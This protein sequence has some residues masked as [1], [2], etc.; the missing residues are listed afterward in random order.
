MNKR[1]SAIF[2][3][4]VFLLSLV[5]TSCSHNGKSSKS[6]NVTFSIDRQTVNEILKNGKPDL[7]ANKSFRT[8]DD[9]AEQTDSAQDETQTQAQD[10][11]EE[12][13]EEEEPEDNSEVENAPYDSIF[14]DVSI[15]GDDQQTKTA[16]VKENEGVS[17]VFRRVPI[18]A[19]VWASA[20][21]YTYTDESKTSKMIVY[22][23]KS[24]SII[25][26]STGNKLS[27]LLEKAKLTVTFDSNGGTEVAP[28]EVVT[29]E[30]L[31]KPENPTLSNKKDVY[32]FMG[33]YTDPEFT[34]LYDFDLPVTQDLTL[35]A[36]WLSDYVLVP[37]GEMLNYLKTG[38]DIL[39]VPEL[40][41]CQHEVTQAEYY[42]V[43][44]KDPSLRDRGT[45]KVDASKYPVENVSWYDAIVYCNLLSIKEGL[46]PCYTIKDSVKPAD[47]GDVPT[48]SDDDWNLVSV[49]L[50]AGGYRL[51]TEAEWEYVATTGMDSTTKAYDDLVLYYS[52]SKNRTQTVTNRLVDGLGIC[53]ILGNVSEWCFDWYSTSIDS[54]A[55]LSGPDYGSS[56]VK[57]GGDYSGT[58]KECSVD[59]RAYAAPYYKD[60]TIGF[61]VARVVHEG[62]AP[63]EASVLY[64][65]TYEIE[66]CDEG[67]LTPTEFYRKEEVKLP[68]SLDREGYIFGGWYKT[69]TYEDDSKITGWGRYE[70]NGDITVYGKWIPITYTIKFN[71]GKSTSTVEMPDQVFTYDEAQELAECAFDAPAGLKF[72]GWINLDTTGHD[73]E[74][75]D[76]DYSDKQEVVNLTS[77][78]GAVITLYALWVNKARGNIKYIIDGS[79]VTG[80]SP[81]SYLPSETVDLPT[82]TTDTTNLART[83]YTFS[84]WFT[85]PGYNSATAITG[86]ASGTKEDDIP[87]YGKF[88]PISY[89]ITYVGEGDVWNWESGYTKPAAYTI[90]DNVTLP[91]ASNVKRD[92]YD[93]GGWYFDS[94]L[95]QAASG[96]WDA[97]RIE[98]VTLYAKWSLH[99]Y[100]IEFNLNDV[101]LAGGTPSKASADNTVNNTVS[102]FT[103]ESGPITLADPSR[104]GYTFNG[105]YTDPDFTGEPITIV[106]PGTGSTQAHSDVPLYAKW[107]INTNH[108][109]YKEADDTSITSL[110][111]PG[112][113]VEDALIALGTPEKSGYDFEGWYK[114]ATCTGTAITSIT[115]GGGSGQ[116]SSDVN[117]Y[118]KWSL[119]EY[120]VN[121]NVNGGDS[122]TAGKFSVEQS[123]TLP[124]PTKAGCYFNGWCTDEDL[125]SSAVAAGTI[126]DYSSS[127]G[128][129]ILDGSN[130]KTLELYAKWSSA[131]VGVTVTDPAEKISLTSS[132]PDSSGVI[133]F[134]ATTDLSA[135][136]T[137]YVDGVEDTSATGNTFTFDRADHTKGVYTITVECGGYSATTSLVA[138]IGTKL[139]PDAVLDIVFTD[140]SAIAYQSGL[141]LSDE[142]KAA[143]VAVI[144]YTGTECSNDSRQRILGLGLKN[145]DSDSTPTYAWAKN[146]STGYSTKFTNIAISKSTQKPTDGTVY[147]Q[148]I[149]N[150]FTGD[151][152]GSDNWSYICLQDLTGTA[153]AEVV[154]EN[155]P[156]FNYVNNYAVKAGLTGIYATGWYMPSL[157]ESHHIY[158]KMTQLNTILGLLN[159]ADIL[160][161][162]YYWSS[163]QIANSN[164]SVWSV[165]F[166]SGDV[167]QD[168]KSNNLRVCVI[169][170]F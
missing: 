92:N 16:L 115:P 23:G 58:P 111:A 152:E 150:Y 9:P 158:K 35:Y 167:P 86:W 14:I 43:T 21:I 44:G 45:T 131:G 95:S 147:Y 26:R 161:Y 102:G 165:G 65:I 166:D 49:N 106:N 10:E 132:A 125:T 11:Y 130:N 74:E 138:A 159:N 163:S 27:I 116:Y 62:K 144:F 59:A 79:E 140:G 137:W 63:E 40:Y 96:G 57:R 122:I 88:E 134:T 18:E 94:E 76:R 108:V 135:N 24:S 146:D 123:L 50:Y 126:F 17:I 48:S 46:T 4:I 136:F 2:V 139:E 51:L 29:G 30:K 25:V 101:F 128:Y 71:K 31:T 149:S 119:I 155:Y 117:V 1:H 160:P 89:T 85:D 104:P 118:A 8:A 100:I 42:A 34:K 47:W 22:R 72:G 84:G 109:Y 87:V 98:P 148:Y 36:K 78:D 90:E 6:T 168:N 112:F 143:A 121:Y 81:S 99:E 52:N 39:I 127:T 55:G 93:F 54:F 69:D 154:A 7:L 28:Q 38:R 60:G 170:E 110:S 151:F 97:G 164:S 20:E 156:A 32:A 67:K 91:S 13:E 53:N 66:G 113:T 153:D 19:V 5:I 107:A 3:I 56:R 129:D 73:D 37:Q 105:W 15:L 80:L 83:G 124:T 68:T 70:Q 61:R 145:S 103:I 75:L 162:E 12:E 64:T 120:T 157:V 33:W 82:S 141:S 77:E 114:D 133:T 169:R 41:V 142:Q